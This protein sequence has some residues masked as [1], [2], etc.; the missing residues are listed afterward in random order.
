MDIYVF[1]SVVSLVFMIAGVLFILFSIVLPYLKKGEKSK[2]REERILFLR[3]FKKG[4]MGIICIPAF[5]LYLIGIL[6]SGKT[7]TVAIAETIPLT[8]RLLTLGYRLDPVRQLSEA[9]PIYHFTMVFVCYM[10]VV[11][12][13]L[14][15]ISLFEQRI[16]FQ[17]STR[18]RKTSCSKIMD[19]ETCWIFGNNTQNNMLYN[20]DPEYGFKRRIIIDKFPYGGDENLFLKGIH[21]GAMGTLEEEANL[22]KDYL[23]HLSD[24]KQKSFTIVIN[25]DSDDSNID[26]ANTYSKVIMD[27][28]SGKTAEEINS[29]LS[30]LSIFIFGNEKYY[31]IYNE[32]EKKS[33][34]CFIHVNKHRIISQNFIWN[35]PFTDVLAKDCIDCDKALLRE[36]TGINVFMIGF[37][38]TNN[39]LFADLVS[40]NQFII[41]DKKAEKGCRPFTANYYLYDSKE[42]IY[43]KELDHNFFRY[44]DFYNKHKDDGRY[45]PMADIPANVYQKF[46]TDI[47]SPDF[48]KSLS[49]VLGTKKKD[50]NIFIVAFGDDL[51]NI[52]FANKL[53]YKKVEWN[54]PCMKIFVKVCSSKY[55]DQCCSEDICVFGADREIYSMM[56]IHAQGL[57][58]LALY[59][60]ME[61]ERLTAETDPDVPKVADRKW[62]TFTR[63]NIERQNSYYAG[64]NYKLKLG[65]MGLEL[66]SDGTDGI[67]SNEE[68]KEHYNKCR[69][70]LAIQE[71]LRWNAFMICNGY[72]PST[73]KEILNPENKGIV[74]E[75]KRHGYLTNHD[76][77]DQYA[78]LLSENFG[79]P[80]EVYDVKKYDTI[81]M[82]RCYEILQSQGASIKRKDS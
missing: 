11:N 9:C 1:V 56:N 75:E 47:N 28:A 60:D 2:Q 69:D 7:L 42:N 34:G 37:G 66:V 39:R 71:H 32:I 14:F 30:K 24:N 78:S 10:S 79:K 64:I 18:N 19:T 5:A 51:E 29:S 74:H 61:F 41:E 46:N 54:I 43:S 27:Y 25:W 53:Y 40:S 72:V 31:S 63:N 50:H 44:L 67:I 73:I 15:A 80:K 16:S 65:L 52:D 8:L 81:M 45:L 35:H 77:L 36:D 76:G 33:F 57:F 48:Y 82:D 26:L 38:K 58:N 23:E 22:L 70:S 49:T 21:Y 20:S 59:A 3:S 17:F 13:S 12:A 55:K 6:Y 4:K 62:Y 68:F